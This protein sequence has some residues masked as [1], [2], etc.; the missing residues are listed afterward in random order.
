MRIDYESRVPW[1]SDK[2]VR[3]GVQVA[4]RKYVSVEVLRRR[5]LRGD[6]PDQ[7]Y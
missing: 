3:E 4:V 6:L 7:G 2:A 1:V 5:N